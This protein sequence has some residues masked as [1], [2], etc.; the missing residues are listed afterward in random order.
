[1]ERKYFIYKLTNIVNGKIYIG[2]TKR[3]L[4]RRMAD[5]RYFAKKKYNAPISRAI[6]KHG[7]E[8]FQVDVIK[9]CQ[10]ESEMNEKEVNFIKEYNALNPLI[11][12]NICDEI[13]D[14]RFA[15][16]DYIK[17]IEKHASQGRKRKNSKYSKYIGTRWWY[18]EWYCQCRIG[19]KNVSKR[20]SSELDAAEL[21]D[22]I[23]LYHYGSKCRLNFEENRTKYSKE[24]LELAFKGFTEITHTS[25]ER[26]VFFDKSRN[27]WGFAKTID[28]RRVFKRFN[29]E[30]E[31]I[32]F[33]KKMEIKL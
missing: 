31:A 8:N 6:A 11:G 18:N 17:K 27:K 20:C 14:H 7:W 24:N 26:Y 1:M 16:S 29:T 15:S 32:E 30:K 12:Y 21:Y 9:E 23:C 10:S 22:K 13:Q 33:K 28:G 25:K 2:K 3:L 5:H 19:G 4:C